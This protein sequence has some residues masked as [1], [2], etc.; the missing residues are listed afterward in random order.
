MIILID[1]QAEFNADGDL[2]IETGGEIIPNN[3][4]LL[5]FEEALFGDL[6][7]LELFKYEGIF[8]RKTGQFSIKCFNKEINKCNPKITVERI[9]L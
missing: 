6:E 5:R 4:A 2:Y 8:Y 3:G 7:I 1:I 9:V